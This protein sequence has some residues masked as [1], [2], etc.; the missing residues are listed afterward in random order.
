MRCLSR[1]NVL[2]LVLLLVQL[3][4]EWRVRVVDAAGDIVEAPPGTEHLVVE[5][6]DWYRQALRATEHG[7]LLHARDCYERAIDAY[8]LLTVAYNNLGTIVFE[9]THNYSLAMDVLT[10]GLAAAHANN[11]T[12]LAASMY[13][14]MGFVTRERNA[15]SVEYSLAAIELFNQALE[16]N[17]TFVSALFNKA[18]AL[19]GMLHDEE[20]EALYLQVLELEPH[21]EGAHLDLGAIYFSRRD[22][23]RAIYHQDEL[24]RHSSDPVIKRGALNNKG[25]FLKEQGRWV[26]ALRVHEEAVRFE[27]EYPLALVNVVTARRTLCIWENTEELQD[28][29]L[30]YVRRQ[31]L[32]NEPGVSSL[33]PYDSTLLSVTDEFRRRLAE[34]HSQ[35]F[36]QSRTLELPARPT[37]SLSR[38]LR[39]GYLSFDF[40]EH[41]M[42]QLTLGLIE[43]HDRS[44]V[45]VLCYSYGPNDGSEWRLRAEI[46]CDEFY[47]CSASS[48]LEVARRIALDQVDILVDLMAH[49]KGARLGITALKPSR[50]IVNYLGFPGTMGSSFTD[51]ALIDRYV[52]PPEIVHA[53]MSERAIYLP[54]IYQ[55]NQFEPDVHVCGA[56]SDC[57]GETRVDQNLPLDAIVF[58]NFNTID[59]ME[60][61]SFTVWMN[62]LRR[63]PV[64][65]LWLLEPAKPHADDIVRRL[66]DQAASRGIDPQRL[67]FAPRLPKRLHLSRLTAADLFLDSFIYNAHSTASDALWANV[68]IV[69]LWGGTF[70]SRVAAALVHAG[71]GLPY[72]LPH[73]TREFEELAVLLAT[74]P[75]LRSRYRQALSRHS[76]A[77]PLFDTHRTTRH[78]ETTYAL[79][80]DI[81]DLTPLGGYRRP[82]QILLAV[83]SARDFAPPENTAARIHGALELGLQRQREQAIDDA[84]YVYRRVLLMNASHAEA[85]HLLGLAHYQKQEFSVASRLISQAIEHNPT[86]A[87]YLQNRAIA[88]IA[89]GDLGAAI[90]D[91]KG[92]L[93]LAPNTPAAFDKLTDVL[94]DTGRYEEAVDVFSTFG[95]SYFDESNP[96]P[97][98]DRIRLFMR[99][100]FVLVRLN[101]SDQAIAVLEHAV[102]RY[103]Q[104]FR[105]AYNLAATYNA[106]GDYAAGDERQVGTAVAEA[107]R[108]LEAEVDG[109]FCVSSYQ[110]TA[111]PSRLRSKVIVTSNALE[112][113][114]FADGANDHTHFVYG[115]SPSRG[116][117]TLLIVWPHIREAVPNAT[118]SV[119][120]GF[121]PAFLAWGQAHVPQFQEWKAEM[122]LLLRQPGVQYHGL[123]DHH[124]LAN[125]Y[126]SAGF[127]LYPTTFSETS[128]V[129]LMKAMANGAIPITSRF[130][131]Y[132]LAFKLLLCLLSPQF[133]FSST[134]KLLTL[135]LKLFLPR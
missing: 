125:A 104:S 120:Y 9:L 107:S 38:H 88:H 13:N 98:E 36:A 93:R 27:P 26:E 15:R 111:F 85:L 66:R 65:V 30:Y 60:P 117:H 63:V 74:R 128:C 37:T 34:A 49:T 108:L 82:P 75:S 118:L 47:D 73:S 11:D 20:A 129:S 95:G 48:D 61:T 83:S 78:I 99:Y 62:I 90:D 121:T 135:T 55:V 115:S 32:A 28:E 46:R 105:L 22:F 64:S 97:D 57:I 54:H 89:N 101:M 31:L 12:A 69:S 29:M 3:C 81:Q 131:D 84:I 87:L 53:T 42:G 94:V 7:D 102:S 23:D 56:D 122:E 1:A 45:S 59:K 132:P 126:A 127:Y 116:L 10:R 43:S 33:L 19:H 4:H 41:P 24:I 96:V 17:A 67:V 77:S 6:V 40:R 100:S 130:V 16:L 44:K 50:T 72:L 79:L 14:N 114:Y 18:S 8:P 112:P 58:C 51:F 124:T 25:Q 2:F 5:A 86:V 110:A 76:L 106:I 92:T 123:V 68:P 113:E 71:T 80:E 39:I 134:A 21:N 109:I 91:L 103:P 70:P 35:T 133:L 119:Y 52:V